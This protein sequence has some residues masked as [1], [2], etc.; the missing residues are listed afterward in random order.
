MSSAA[1]LREI[2]AS[3]PDTSLLRI[4]TT[5]APP[6]AALPSG[7][8]EIDTLLSGGLPR[9]RLCE[10][11]GPRSAGRTALV[12]AMLASA[13]RR[14]EVAAI[15]DLEDALDP[16]SLEAAGTDLGRVL[17]VRPSSVVDGLRAAD[18]VLEAGGFGLVVLDIGEARGRRAGGGAGPSSRPG[19]L[20]AWARLTHG[21]E[22]S[23]TALVVLGSQSFAG[24]HAALT[25]EVSRRSA[26]FS[27]VGDFPG[28]RGHPALLDRIDSSVRLA[29]ARFQA[30]GGE[31]G[32]DLRFTAA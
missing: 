15:V 22:R 32:S 27:P 19:R 13:T 23:G 2:L 9:G 14:G 16:A 3:L 28:S 18:L 31:V 24:S 21:A 5:L 17:W 26:S 10:I 7:L 1:S 29:R 4:A 25:L 6:R 12:L 20:S 30:P 11:V 8:P